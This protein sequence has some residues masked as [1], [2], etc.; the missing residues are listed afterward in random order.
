MP[1]MIPDD[2]AGGSV[3]KCA[4]QFKDRRAKEGRN[5]ATTTRGVFDY[6]DVHFRCARP[7]CNDEQSMIG[8]FHVSSTQ[9]GLVPRVIAKAGPIFRY[10]SLYNNH[11]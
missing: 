1:E 11:C 8:G 9:S 7:H 6:T 10:T 3:N 5:R 2:G 4:E